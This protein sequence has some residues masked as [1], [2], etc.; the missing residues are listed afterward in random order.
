MRPLLRGG[1]QVR[2]P[3]QFRSGGLGVS[4]PQCNIATR[5][6]EC[7]VVLKLR[8]HVVHN[9]QC[10]FGPTRVGDR[11]R[12]IDLDDWRTGHTVKG[13]IQGDDG[14]PIGLVMVL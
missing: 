4:Q 8:G 13:A 10:A 12:A 7:V 9:P 6:V 1:G 2:G 11:N 3:L 5:R 14:A